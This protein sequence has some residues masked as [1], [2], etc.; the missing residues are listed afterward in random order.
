M[1]GVNLGR[2]SDIATARER[3][4][5]RA[6]LH[7]REAFEED[8]KAK[9]M[10]LVNERISTF[11]GGV[12]ASCAYAILRSLVSKLSADAPLLDELA[13][14]Q[15]CPVGEESLQQRLAAFD[16]GVQRYLPEVIREELPERGTVCITSAP[17]GCK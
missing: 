1:R 5:Y 4:E 9:A 15:R 16:G 2:V 11:S 7:E 14:L 6:R 12:S 13:Q 3:R 17:R 10:L 8:V